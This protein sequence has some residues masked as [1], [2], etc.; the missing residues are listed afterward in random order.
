[1]EFSPE[2]RLR[3]I[4]LP[5]GKIEV[6]SKLWSHHAYNKLYGRYPIKGELPFDFKY[7]KIYEILEPDGK[8][9]I[10]RGDV[11]FIDDWYSVNRE[12]RGQ[13]AVVLEKYRITK[14]KPH[15]IF[16]DYHAAVLIIS[17]PKKGKTRKYPTGKLMNQRRVGVE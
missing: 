1:M 4:G 14:Y 8:S 16:R 9:R 7:Q 11:V 6:N 5:V 13:M 12:C 10:N 15:G 2:E 17:G 3:N